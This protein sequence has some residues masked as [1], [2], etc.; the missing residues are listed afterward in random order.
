[1]S[2]L[3]IIIDPSVTK[4]LDSIRLSPARTFYCENSCRVNARRKDVTKK[5]DEYFCLYC[6]KK[7]VTISYTGGMQS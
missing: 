7:I 5:G 2:D 3:Q 6:T 4:L 1:M